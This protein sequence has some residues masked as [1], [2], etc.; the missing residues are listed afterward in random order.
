MGVQEITQE[1]LDQ[2]NTDI[3]QSNGS[4]QELKVKYLGKKG[5]VTGLMKQMGG[6]SQEER[7]VFGQAVNILRKEIEVKVETLLEEEEK[8]KLSESLN[9]GYEDI[10]KQAYGIE[11]GSS[12]PVTLVRDQIIDFF[13]GMG[14]SV[15]AGREIETD[16]YNFEALN[17]PEDH[18]A[19]DMQDT[20]YIDSE[21][22][23]RTQTSGI[24]IH[25]M[26]ESQP[27]LKIIAPGYVYRKDMDASHAPM[28]SQ[29]EGLVVDKDISFAHLKGTLFLWAQSMFGKDVNIRFRPSYFPFTEPSAEM[30]V[31]CVF[32]SGK[33]C[34]V[35]KGCGWIEIGGCGSVNPA[36]LEKVNIDSEEY[37]GFAF[38]FGIERMTMLKYQ[39][40]EIG[41]LTA[42][43][44]RFLKQW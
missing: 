22:V 7:P 2:F 33:G 29:V 39:I 8:R 23:L 16:F 25:V 34:R 18:P 44:N 12:H 37:T 32:C 28:F 6:L 38:G 20:F 19:R 43:D 9:K 26:E 5:L 36:V 41:L 3:E 11:P 17:I 15:Q 24:Q 13:F 10:S 42:N 14:F 35:C 27:P 21:V 30:D 1:I 40:P 31:S 4:V